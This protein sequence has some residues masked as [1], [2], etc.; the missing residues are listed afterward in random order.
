MNLGYQ[1]SARNDQSSKVMELKS[2]GDGAKLQA[3]FEEKLEKR[4]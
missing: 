2:Y 4:K 1:T 3:E